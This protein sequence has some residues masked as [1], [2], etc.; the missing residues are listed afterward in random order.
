MLKEE[1]I[2]NKQTHIVTKVV[3]WEYAGSFLKRKS[4]ERMPLS[5]DT[6]HAMRSEMSLLVREEAKLDAWISRLRNLMGNP[7]D[8][9]L[10]YLTPSDVRYAVNIDS[11][12]GPQAS[13][14]RGKRTKTAKKEPAVAV[15]APFGTMV[16]S[17]TPISYQRDSN[18]ERTRHLVVS[19]TEPGQN[20]DESEKEDQLQVYFFPRSEY[21][22]TYALHDNPVLEWIREPRYT[23]ETN[24]M[25]GAGDSLHVSCL[26]ED[27]GVSSFF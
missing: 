25:G 16:Q 23:S 13:S 8:P 4:W 11:E 24:G 27:E 5:E 2:R 26:K 9:E 12:A 19:C 7:L 10:M 1:E 18:G 3:W 14:S 6:E 17:S 15:H 22:R 21:R 20:E